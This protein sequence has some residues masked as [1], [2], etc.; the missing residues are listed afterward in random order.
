MRFVFFLLLVAACADGTGERVAPPAAAVPYDL[1]APDGSAE[2]PH[3]LDEISGLTMLPS[4]RLGAVQD[5][6]GTLYEIE[7]T[8]GTITGTQPFGGRG[9]YEGVEW[10]G[11]SVWTLESNG[12]LTDVRRA[13]D[14]AEAVPHETPLRGRNDTEGLAWDG[15][16]LL[17][18]CKENPGR[19]LDGVRAIWAYDPATRALSSAPVAVLDRTAVDDGARFKPSA[20]AVHPETRELYVLSSVRK[21]LAVLAPDGALRTV[22]PLSDRIFRQ[23]EGIAFDAAGTL[24]IANEGAGARASLLRFDAR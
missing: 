13:G 10:V 8:T 4:G 24:Y 16:R 14:A 1:G 21:A 15:E 23:P 19:G 12:D 2:L 11:E 6:D 9:D 7:P 17:I 22:V 3:E 5:E 18:A 20:L